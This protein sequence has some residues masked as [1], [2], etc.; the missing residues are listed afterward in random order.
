M[1]LVHFLRRLR[2]SAVLRSVGWQMLGSAA[3][4]GTALWISWNQGLE[5]QGE[6]GLAKSWF[7]A[8]AAIA[9]LGLP[10]GLL[11]LMYRCGISAHQVLPWI[12][13]ILTVA[14]ILCLPTA[15]VAAALGQQTS[16]L[17]LASLP[18]AI[19][20][21]LAR[22]WLLRERGEEVFGV[23]TA[24]PA[25]VLLAAVLLGGPH[26]AWLLLGT[27]CIAGTT[28]LLLVAQTV[29]RARATAGI[30]TGNAL[31]TISPRTATGKNLPAA[32]TPMLRRELWFSSLQIW[33]QA[34]LG[35]ALPAGL[36]SIVAQFGQ[37]QR[38]LGETSLGL[39]IYQVFTVLAGY[40]A[41]LL[42]HRIAGHRASTGL[43]ATAL[44]TRSCQALWSLSTILVLS[45]LVGVALQPNALW[46]AIGLMSL[47]GAAAVAARL[48]STVLL[49]RS[50]Y[51]EL[52]LQAT[53]R[54]L[55]ALLATVLALRFVPAL[56]AVSVAL[57]LTEGLTWW[58][59]ARQAGRIQATTL[60]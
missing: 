9:A 56:V 5:A 13:R 57:L 37:T 44:S 55:L 25:L 4:L 51:F 17:V 28:S 45:M 58:R 8:A 20:H 60:T 39:Q 30:H 16:A 34:A 38:A 47:A 31:E 7:D 33:M 26:Y 52:S 53:S 49:A 10:H 46:P 40:V 11:H 59:S 29:R 42:F 27:A 19:A 36:L 1:S 18:F 41:P 23:I 22:S 35:G 2:I 54:L 21:L 43:D 32:S 48:H 24:M 15:A 12:H 50:E 3:T 6:F 14:A